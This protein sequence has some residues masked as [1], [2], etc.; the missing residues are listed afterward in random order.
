[1]PPLKLSLLC[2]SEHMINACLVHDLGK[3][4]LCTKIILLA[5]C[6]LIHTEQHECVTEWKPKREV[7]KKDGESYLQR[8]M[9]MWLLNEPVECL[10][11]DR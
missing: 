9:M 7:H 10:T 11:G 4:T 6:L 1:M 3:L 8:I 2:P 5:T